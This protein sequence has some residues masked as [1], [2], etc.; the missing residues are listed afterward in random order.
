MKEYKGFHITK[1]IQGYFVVYINDGFQRFDDL[2]DCKN[3]INEEIK[4]A[5]DE[6]K[7]WE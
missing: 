5:L 7:R 3:A 2:R 4:R 6:K 1:N